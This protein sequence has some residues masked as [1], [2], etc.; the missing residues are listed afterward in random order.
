[1]KI[2]SLHLIVI[3]LSLT[4]PLQGQV[5][6]S[7]QIDLSREHIEE[8]ISNSPAFSIYKDN[9]FL[10]GFPLNQRI[11][12]YN[13]D[14]KFQISFKQ[15]L[16]DKPVFWGS[17][18]YITYTQKSFWGIYQESKPF[19]ET[20]YNPGVA[21]VKPI[22]KNNIL[23]GAL[24][25]TGEHESNGRDKEESRSWNFISAGYTHF[26]SEDSYL[27]LRLWLPFWYKDDNPNLMDYI[28]YGEV[29]F[30]WD[31]KKDT[32]SLKIKGKKGADLHRHGSVVTDFTWRP[33]KERNIYLMT[34]W[35]LGYSE[36]LI[37]YDES[38]NMIRFGISLKPEF[39]RIY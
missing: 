1:M 12:K 23:K 16:K 14:A 3:L 2:S 18:F 33:F 13:S 7:K 34:Q 22:Y 15:R 35:W 17:Y 38:V 30:F 20:N 8:S 19:E 27:G 11:T 36:S 6:L 9:Y 4:S 21:L 31:I 24:M 28:G 39:L 5:D 32:F 10:T 29:T 26:F 37:H 25:F